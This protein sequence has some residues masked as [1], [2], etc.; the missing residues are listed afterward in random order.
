MLYLVQYLTR[1]NCCSWSREDAR[2]KDVLLIL[3]V[4][5]SFTKTAVLKA[6]GQKGSHKRT[7]IGLPLSA[8]CSGIHPTGLFW[9]EGKGELEYS[10]N[11]W[12]R[13]PPFLSVFT[14]NIFIGSLHHRIESNF[15]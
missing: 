10:S 4:L 2:A 6:S 11:G 15:I 13:R 12:V 3:Q 8:S 7:A 9:K 14:T 5:S 1:G